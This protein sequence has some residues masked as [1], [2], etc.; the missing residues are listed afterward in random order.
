M[1]KDSNKNKVKTYFKGVNSEIKKVTWPSKN[2]LFKYTLTVVSI[3]ILI[4][5]IVGVLDLVT[6]RLI[7]LLVS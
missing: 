1:S 5:V 4:A 2:E 7:N 6:G 3:S